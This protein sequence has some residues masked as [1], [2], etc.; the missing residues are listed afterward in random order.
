[1]QCREARGSQRWWDDNTV[2]IEDNAITA[3]QMS[4]ELVVFSDWCWKLVFELWESVFNSG[5]EEEHVLI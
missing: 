1:M 3:I 5:E 2:F 4:P